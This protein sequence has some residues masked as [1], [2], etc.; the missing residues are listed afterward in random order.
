MNKNK[1]I[2]KLHKLKEKHPEQIIVIETPKDHIECKLQNALIYEDGYGRIIIDSTEHKLNFEFKKG[3]IMFDIKE[4][5]FL[6]NLL[7]DSESQDEMTLHL[8]DKINNII[9]FTNE[10]KKCLWSFCWEYGGQGKIEGLFKATK[11]DIENAIGKNVYFGEVLGK[12]SEIYGVFEE[13]DITLVSDNPIEVINAYENG[14]N[15]LNYITYYCN[16][17]QRY[18]SKD[19]YNF[20]TNKCCYCK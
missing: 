8:I 10:Y 16:E 2:K 1:I 11:E 5:D 7:K 14:Y 3:D 20:E 4:L 15:P 17:C 19:E 18:V 12:N 6:K 13:M 9:K